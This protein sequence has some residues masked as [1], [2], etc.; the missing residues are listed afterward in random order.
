MKLYVHIYNHNVTC[1]PEVKIDVECEN[2]PRK[3]DIFYVGDD[4]LRKLMEM[5]IRTGKYSDCWWYMNHTQYSFDDAIYVVNVLW[6][7]DEDGVY[8]CHIELGDP[9][10][11]NER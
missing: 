2:A 4:A 3:G 9:F 1:D 10:M 8:R 11:E 7:R 6:E 5:S